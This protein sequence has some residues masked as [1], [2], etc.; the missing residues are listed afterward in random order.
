MRDFMF[1]INATIELDDNGVPPLQQ[2]DDQHIMDLILDSDRF[3]KAQ[4]CR[5]NYGR[6]F[7]QAS[8]IVGPHGCLRWKAWS[9]VA[10]PHG[11][12]LIKIGHRRKNGNCGGRQISY[13]AVRMEHFTCLWKIGGM[14]VHDSASNTLHNSDIAAFTFKLMQ[15]SIKS[16]SRH[17]SQAIFAFIQ[18]FASTPQLSPMH[19]RLRFIHLV[20]IPTTGV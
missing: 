4:I 2:H 11:S 17:R 3:T 18:D 14:P 9:T 15:Y 1:M 16:V 19:V 10:R 20:T 6:L 7:F 13:G 12:K 5:L 8:H